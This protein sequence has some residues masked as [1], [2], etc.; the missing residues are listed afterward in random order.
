MSVAHALDAN[1][2]S[3][4]E[5]GTAT[6]FVSTQDVG[7]REPDAALDGHAVFQSR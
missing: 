5:S 4:M 3:R 7:R 6:P 2:S 1:S